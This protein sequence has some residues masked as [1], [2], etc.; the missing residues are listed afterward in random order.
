M[1]TIPCVIFAGGRSSRMGADK[2]LLP[3]GEFSTLTEFQVNKLQKIFTHVYVSCKNK[4][5]FD[6]EANFI[7]DLQT[8]TT[9]APTSGFIAI[10]EELKCSRF[11]ALS[12][13]T[14]FVQKTEIMRLLDDD[15]DTADATIAILENKMQPM[16]GIYHASLYSSFKEMLA[17]NQHK[18][19]YLLKHSHTRYVHFQNKRSF[20]NLNTPQD[21]QEAL[22]L[23]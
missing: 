1:I 6:F 4:N 21:Y 17:S 2:A 14:P 11:F 19:G 3:F 22:T 12:V 7:E 15:T 23:V 8:D 18:L 10:F 5:S 9:Y 20:L 13:D 16:C